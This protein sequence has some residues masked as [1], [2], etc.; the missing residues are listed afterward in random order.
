M[1]QTF[2]YAIA[3]IIRDRSFDADCDA[4]TR[5][6]V[7]R[8]ARKAAD[9]FRCGDPAFNYEWFFGACGLDHWGDLLP[10]TSTTAS[11]AVGWDP[12]DNDFL[13]DYEPSVASLG[14][15]PFDF[16]ATMSKIR[17]CVSC[18]GELVARSSNSNALRCVR[19]SWPMA[20]VSATM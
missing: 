12:H 8:F 10:P 3:E 6:T 4:A 20:R 2:Y 19:M 18:P 15:T 11:Q 13:I 14:A 17:T 16:H 5:D 7:A 1:A 9:N